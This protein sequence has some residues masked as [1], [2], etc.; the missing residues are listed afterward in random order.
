MKN[1]IR[2][3]ICRA[4]TIILRRYTVMS[5][6]LLCRHTVVVVVGVFSQ[7]FSLAW[8]ISWIGP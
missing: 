8:A 2:I 4:K 3:K 5:V 7:H 6:K 1:N